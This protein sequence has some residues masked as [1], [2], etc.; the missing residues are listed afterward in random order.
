MRQDRIRNEVLP[1][2]AEA[3][4]A[5]DVD[6]IRPKSSRVYLSPAPL[7]SVNRCSA[8]SVHLPFSVVLSLVFVLLCCFHTPLKSVK[9]YTMDPTINGWWKNNLFEPH[10]DSLK[11]LQVVSTNKTTS[12]SFWM[13]IS[14]S[15]FEVQ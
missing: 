9:Q 6:K 5:G 15:S 1:I 3:G 14:S 8:E 4:D 13:L 12:V 7:L 10:K 11:R 2:S